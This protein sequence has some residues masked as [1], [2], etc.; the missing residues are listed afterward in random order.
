MQGQT[1]PIFS[2]SLSLLSAKDRVKES[3]EKLRASLKQ[4]DRDAVEK[5]IDELT[6]VIHRITS[7]LYGASSGTEHGKTAQTDDGESDADP[8]HPSVKYA[9]EMDSEPDG[10]P[11]QKKDESAEGD[12]PSD[13]KKD[14]SE[15]DES[16][17]A[18][19]SGKDNNEP[20]EKTGKNKNSKRRKG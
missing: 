7:E 2:L 20:D 12:K 11:E 9:Y 14:H 5:G 19:P 17:T 10:L 15:D 6:A 13:A 18:K 4:D 1:L 8:G 3:A 16:D